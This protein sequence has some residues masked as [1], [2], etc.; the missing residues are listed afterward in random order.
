M[1]YGSDGVASGLALDRDSRTLGLRQDSRVSCDVAC[2]YITHESFSR[3]LYNVLSSFICSVVRLGIRSDGPA[4]ACVARGCDATHISY[5]R[6]D[7]GSPI[8]SDAAGAR[9]CDLCERVA[10]VIVLGPHRSACRARDAAEYLSINFIALRRCSCCARG[11][12]CC[13]WCAVVVR[14]AVLGRA[15]APRSQ[16]W[17]RD[18]AAR[19]RNRF[20]AL[21]SALRKRH[22]VRHVRPFCP[23]VDHSR[24]REFGPRSPRRQRAAL[25]LHERQSVLEA[26]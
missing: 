25:V 7:A 8:R 3:T 14:G 17:Y 12:A 26:A 13:C 22:G 4:A 10:S 16:R 5:A 21:A 9:R 18:G 24:A 6:V 23:C 1:V 15:A 19:S 11:R 2:T 20:S